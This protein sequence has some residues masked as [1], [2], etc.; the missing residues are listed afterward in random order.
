MTRLQKL[1][2]EGQTPAMPN[3]GAGAYLIEYLFEVGPIQSS[4]VGATPIEWGELESW[5]RITGINLQTWEARTLR[6]LSFDYCATRQ[7]ALSPHCP[8]P[9]SDEPTPDQRELVAKKIST[10]LRGWGQTNRARH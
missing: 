6:Q 3:A 4:G 7:D 9:Y 5:Q 1:K 10:A 2:S 8:P